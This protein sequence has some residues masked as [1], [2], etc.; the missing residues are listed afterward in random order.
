M[1]TRILSF[2]AAGL[3]VCSSAKAQT[4]YGETFKSRLYIGTD[5]QLGFGP[6]SLIDISPLAGYNINRHLSAGIGLTYIFFSDNTIS[7]AM[8]TN[9]FGGRVFTRI[10]PLPDALPGIYLHVGA[11]SINNKQAVANP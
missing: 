6:I 3:L 11:E 4:E 7:P 8:R 9:L 2:I 5:F 10:V 1:F